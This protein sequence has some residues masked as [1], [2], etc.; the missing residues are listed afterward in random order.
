MTNPNYIKEIQERAAL[1]GFT[2]ADVCREAGLDPSVASRW[3][4]GKVTPLVSSIHR[5]KDA[6]DRLIAQRIESIDKIG[7]P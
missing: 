4:A 2:M 6:A 1:A 5:L 3:K 7:Q